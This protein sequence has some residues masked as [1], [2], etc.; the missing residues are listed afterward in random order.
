MTT[1]EFEI[2]EHLGLVDIEQTIDGLE[3]HYYEA[4]YEEIEPVGILN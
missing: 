1:R 2:G 3:F 4:T